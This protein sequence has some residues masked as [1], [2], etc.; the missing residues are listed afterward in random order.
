MATLTTVGPLGSPLS[1][2]YGGFVLLGDGRVV[3][4]VKFQEIY[5][6]APTNS[7]P[8]IEKVMD[9]AYSTLVELTDGQ[10]VKL[11]EYQRLFIQAAT[12]AEAPTIAKV[13]SPGYSGTTTN[14]GTIS[15][16]AD[17]YGKG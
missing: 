9:S 6:A 5:N 12:L 15:R 3:S 17:Q 7:K 1:T 10:V 13:L 16:L 14:N 11:G 4:C 8:T 2:A